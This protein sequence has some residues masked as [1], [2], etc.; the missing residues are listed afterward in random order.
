MSMKDKLRHNILHLAG[1]ILC[2]I[3]GLSF[4]ENI[5]QNVFDKLLTGIVTYSVGIMAVAGAW[6]A[7]L[8]PELIRISRQITIDDE[9]QMIRAS[10]AEFQLSDEIKEVSFNH[11][12]LEDIT[13]LQKEIAKPI[14]LCAGSLLLAILLS[15]FEQVIP[16]AIK[17]IPTLFNTSFSLFYYLKIVAAITLFY[18]YFCI[19]RATLLLLVP[20]HRLDITTELLSKSKKHPF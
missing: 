15:F 3:A 7:V 5:S 4:G 8:F 14:L 2:I 9:K 1:A 18:L 10:H 19:I 12:E 16:V 11:K 20:T 17:D 13:K 6:Y